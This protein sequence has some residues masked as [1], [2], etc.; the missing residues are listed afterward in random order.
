MSEASPIVIFAYRRHKHL[1]RV[2]RSLSEQSLCRSSRAFVFIDGPK[3]DT[4]RQDVEEVKRVAESIWGFSKVSILAA[5]SNL[6]LDR[7]INEGITKILKEYEQA[8]IVEDD[9][10]PLPD[11]LD[12]MN[13]ALSRYKEEKSIMQISGFAYP[14]RTD[15]RRHF[16]LP[17]TSCWGWATWRRSWLNHS[18][19]RVV[20]AQELNNPSFVKRM[21]LEGAYPFSDLLRRVIDGKGD[22]WDVIWYWKV[23]R[24]GGLTL[25]PGKSLVENIGW[26]GSGT[27]GEKEEDSFG[28]CGLSMP[29]GNLS[30]PNKIH[31]IPSDLED[32]RECIIQRERKRKAC[33]GNS[34]RLVRALRKLIFRTPKVDG[35]NPIPDIY[36][37]EK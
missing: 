35:P 30:W 8:I 2:L 13:E 22:C 31:V 11:F 7:S 10:L 32:V 12:F 6:G 19:D 24:A 15:H 34:G 9:I 37:G 26:D 4:D 36:E 33:K 17:I 16:F 21:D 1:A 28:P 29:Y 25:F 14:R 23:M 3:G 27:H 18:L 20:A 5:Q